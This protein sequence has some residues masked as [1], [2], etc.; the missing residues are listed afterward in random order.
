MPMRPSLPRSFF[1]R[2]R[3][4]CSWHVSRCRLLLSSSRRSRPSQRFDNCRAGIQALLQRRPSREELAAERDH[5][6]ELGV[7]R[8]ESA[9][10]IRRAFRRR[11]KECH[12]DCAGPDCEEQFK[13]LAQAHEVLS[14]PATRRDYDRSLEDCSRPSSVFEQQRRRPWRA[15][16]IAPEPIA[17][18]PMADPWLR[19]PRS[20]QTTTSRRAVLERTLLLTPREAFTG[21]SIP[22][23]FVIERACPACGGEGSW[24]PRIC[25]QCKGWGSL[26]EE[27]QVRLQLPPRLRQGDV[28]QEE[29]L[30]DPELPPLFVVLHVLLSPAG[31]VL[32]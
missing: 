25:F 16:P 10:G 13:A 28:L 21:G 6:Q 29:L 5:Y 7:T 8:D 14:D 20:R 11:A 24:G 26:R 22:L 3:E 4:Q 31:E 2:P 32:W 19:R 17:P 15:E 30:L 9:E 12:P 18:E 23:R 27:R 1:D